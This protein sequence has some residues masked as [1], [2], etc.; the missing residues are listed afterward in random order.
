MIPQDEQGF[1]ADKFNDW[2]GEPIPNGWNAIDREL[3]PAGRRRFPFWWIFPGVL[4]LG[5]AGY[6]SLRTAPEKPASATQTIAGKP[7]GT[8]AGQQ[9]RAA[10]MRPDG[11]TAGT[12]TLGVV[13]AGSAVASSSPGSDGLRS[14][15]A[16]PVKARV[17]LSEKPAAPVSPVLPPLIASARKGS[18]GRP[19]ESGL[20]RQSGSVSGTPL[21]AFAAAAN[22]PLQS[23]EA[24]DRNVPV[25]GTPD[26]AGTASA[27]PGP[28]P[29]ARQTLP[30]FMP[31]IRMARLE[32]PPLKEG[33]PLPVVSEP[34]PP[35]PF[36]PRERRRFSFAVTGQAAAGQ[37]QIQINQ[38]EG[39]HHMKMGNPGEVQSG[40][41][42][43]GI[44]ARYPLFRWLE[45]FGGFSLTVYRLQ[46]DILNTPRVPSGFTL[47]EVASDSLRYLVNPR[48]SQVKETRTQTQVSLQTEVGIQPLLWSGQGRSGPFASLVLWTRLLEDRRSTTGAAGSF[49]KP[50]RVWAPGY[51]IGYRHSMG[52]WEWE[53]FLSSVPEGLVSSTRGLSLSTRLFGVGIR[54]KIGR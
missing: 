39:L 10:V 29:E 46:L 1:L 18:A 7:S 12:R 11:A 47:S 50:A 4:F 37:N 49:E 9:G 2:S 35:F 3:R 20:S 48:W 26:G 22:V 45:A 8:A 30:E 25:T 28:A 54:R 23:S 41:V 34:L 17:A 38:A 51:R 24:I 16:E 40:M 15:P 5:T 43:A 21:Q 52:A 53:G 33:H 42:S 32:L 44:Q 14:G 36:S 6:L 27:I 19:E 13:T 31:E